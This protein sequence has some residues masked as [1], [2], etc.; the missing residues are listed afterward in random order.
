MRTR[1]NANELNP[2]GWNRVA[3]RFDG[4]TRVGFSPAVGVFARFA[5]V[6]IPVG[7]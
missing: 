1:A 4:A 5:Y 6:I 2:N 3:R 7:S